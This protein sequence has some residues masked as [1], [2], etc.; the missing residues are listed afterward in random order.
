MPTSDSPED[1]VTLYWDV[2]YMKP[3]ADWTDYVFLG[4]Y[5]DESIEGYSLDWV[6]EISKG[7]GADDLE[8]ELY[9]EPKQGPQV[10]VE[11]TIQI[12]EMAG[13]QTHLVWPK[14]YPWTEF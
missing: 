12:L 4:D 6:L 3:D 7:S 5:E 13:N 2:C 8:A 11:D 9:F 10:H 1:D 14:N